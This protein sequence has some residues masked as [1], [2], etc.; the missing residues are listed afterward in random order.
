MDL[1]E[2]KKGDSFLD[3]LLNFMKMWFLPTFT[4]FQNIFANFII[5]GY[6]DEEK[7]FYANV[8][9]NCKQVVAKFF[10]KLPHQFNNFFF[11]L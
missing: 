11:E 3:F 9:K 6:K 10:Q 4:E 5:P 8:K 7:S 2:E 1:F